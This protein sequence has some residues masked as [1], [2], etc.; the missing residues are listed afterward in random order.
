MQPH[1]LTKG[2]ST[3]LQAPV[4][5]DEQPSIPHDMRA[6]VS[7][8]ETVLAGMPE[9]ERDSAAREYAAGVLEVFRRRRAVPEWLAAVAEPLLDAPA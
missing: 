6:F 9:E 5:A 7:I 8:R 1:R 3:H 2:E 4:A